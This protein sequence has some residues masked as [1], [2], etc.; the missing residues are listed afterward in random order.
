MNIKLLSLITI[1][2]I[3][4]CACSESSIADDTLDN[5]S[6]ELFAISKHRPVQGTIIT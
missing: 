3:T 4:L 6:W 2:T 1:L 5:T